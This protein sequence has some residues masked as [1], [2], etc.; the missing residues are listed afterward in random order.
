MFAAVTQ[1]RSMGKQVA[2]VTQPRLMAPVTERHESQQAA[3]RGMLAQQFSGDGSVAYIDMSDA[4]ALSNPAFC[5][6]G[7]HLTAE[8]NARLGEAL[9]Q[10]LEPAIRRAAASREPRSR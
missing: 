3:L 2:V 9:A 4:V 6:D 8:G 10:A 5:Y 1:A 7:M